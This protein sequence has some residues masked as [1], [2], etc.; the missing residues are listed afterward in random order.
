VFIDCSVC[1]CVENVGDSSTPLVCKPLWKEQRV[2]A[3]SCGDFD[4]HTTSAHVALT[5][6]INSPHPLIPPR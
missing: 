6:N 3:V 1:K 2:V 4:F 5:S